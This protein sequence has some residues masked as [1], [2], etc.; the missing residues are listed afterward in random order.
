M[1][2]SNAFHQLKIFMKKDCFYT[3]L[4]QSVE[5]LMKYLHDSCYFCIPMDEYA[6]SKCQLNNN[7]LQWL[8]S[9]NT[10]RTTLLTYHLCMHHLANSIKIYL[11]SSR[12]ALLIQVWLKHKKKI[13]HQPNL[14]ILVVD[15]FSLVQSTVKAHQYWHVLQQYNES[16]PTPEVLSEGDPDL[17]VGVSV[18]R[19]ENS[20]IAQ[21]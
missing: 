11:K 16:L 4:K 8:Q 3:I 5:Y 2:N 13:C 19:A 1:Q 18:I 20:P 7:I 10:F 21:I 14:I 6:Y 17:S 12:A 9:S 15:C